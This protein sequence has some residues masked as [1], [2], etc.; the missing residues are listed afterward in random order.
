MS[1]LGDIGGNFRFRN[2]VLSALMNSPLADTNPA[3]EALLYYLWQSHGF[4]FTGYKRPTLMR[5]VQYRMQMLPM[6]SYSNYIDYL[7]KQPEEFFHL[8]NTIEINVTKFFRNAS[9]WDYVTAQVIPQIIANQAPDKPIRA[10]SAG[11]AS[12]EETYTL[13]MV[14][15]EALGMEQ[16]RSRVQIFGTDVDKEAL[17]QARQGSYLCTEVEGIPDDL[18]EKYFEP[19]NGRYV[20][21]KDLRRCII[22]SH[23]NLIE[24][25]PMSKIDL[26][27]CRNTL[28]YFNLDAQIRVLVRFHFSMKDN[29]FLFLGNTEIV[30]SAIATLFKPMNLQNRIFTKYPKDNLSPR[31]L[32]KALKSSQ[33]RGK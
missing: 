12:G 28:I 24:D 8:F 10:W 32:V 22:F 2:I 14:L 4:D 13:A 26:L 16:F 7:K 19:A 21:R 1:P 5:R 17:S 6:E 3:F 30:P 9:A 11:C 31:L 20:F 23:H 29:G 27:V 18:L 15:A 25:A 33:P